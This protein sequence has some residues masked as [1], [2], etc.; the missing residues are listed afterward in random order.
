MAALTLATIKV[1]EGTGGNLL[2]ADCAY[3]FACS[4]SG[5]CHLRIVTST[6][7]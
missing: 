1:D 5:V 7:I 3:N 2:F 6:T 4:D